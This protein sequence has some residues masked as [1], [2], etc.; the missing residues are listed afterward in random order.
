[1]EIEFD[2]R[3]I[4]TTGSDHSVNCESQMKLNSERDVY[5]TGNHGIYL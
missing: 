4:L 2:D 3:A 1:M 5:T